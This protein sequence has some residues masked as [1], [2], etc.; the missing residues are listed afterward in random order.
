MEERT[1]LKGRTQDLKTQL[2]SREDHLINSQDQNSELKIEVEGTKRQM[3]KLS[4][5]HLADTEQSQ[6]EMG[7]NLAEQGFFVQRHK[8]T[9]KLQ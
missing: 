1:D 8:E 9:A 4:N 3:K 5:D 7:H 2:A 6:K